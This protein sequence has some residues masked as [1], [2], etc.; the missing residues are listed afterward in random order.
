MPRGSQSALAVTSG[1]NYDYETEKIPL[2]DWIRAID[3]GAA[4]RIILYLLLPTITLL[5]AVTNFAR[6]DTFLIILLFGVGVPVAIFGLWLELRS[7]SRQA[8]RI[9]D[10]SDE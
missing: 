9:R 7:I 1:L 3:P 10:R 4:F 2:R 8:R 5:N 6:R